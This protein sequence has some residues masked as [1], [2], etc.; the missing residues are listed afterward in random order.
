MKKAKMLTKL[1]NMSGPTRL[2]IEEKPL[3]M[4]GQIT[5]NLLNIRAKASTDSDV[6]GKLQK[7][8]VVEIIGI[9]EKWYE[10]KL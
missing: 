4:K 5:A 6:V 9:G 1:K 10:I 7:N 2:P 3:L 8:D